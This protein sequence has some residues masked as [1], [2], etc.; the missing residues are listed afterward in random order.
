[1]RN[2]PSRGA[3]SK[4]SP[5][6]KLAKGEISPLNTADLASPSAADRFVEVRASVLVAL[7]DA[8]AL[9]GAV[10]GNETGEQLRLTD[11]MTLKGEKLDVA[12]LPKLLQQLQDLVPHPSE[13]PD[14]L[15][16]DLCCRLSV[17]LM[18]LDATLENASE[19]CQACIL[20][21]HELS[22]F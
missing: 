17:V 20:N 4:T 13:A 14:S 8:M 18:V 16:D 12:S 22:A 15:E 2:S 19:L 7:E 1:M 5:Q 11:A 6:L 21:A 3:G 10:L 9:C